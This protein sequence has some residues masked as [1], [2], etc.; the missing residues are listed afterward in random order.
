[1]V[2]AAPS[3]HAADSLIQGKRLIVKNPSGDENDRTLIVLGKER[4]TDNSFNNTPDPVTASLRVI[5]N[6]DAPSDVTYPLVAPGVWQ[7]A[8]PGISGILKFTG[9]D[10][11]KL[12][13]LKF[14]PAANPSFILKAKLKGS[15]GAQS[16]D[17]LPPN[18]GTSGGIIFT[19]DQGFGEER[20]CVAF[21][22]A[23]GG[24]TAVNDASMW[25]V[26]NANL[27]G[28]PE[29]EGPPESVSVS[30]GSDDTVTTDS[31]SDGA[32]TSD[33]L[34]TF[35][36]TPASGTVTISEAT[37]TDPNPVGYDLVGQ[38]ADVT[39]PSATASDPLVLTFLIDLT[40]IPPGQDPATIQV[41]RDGVAVEACLG[42]PG[43]AFPDPCVSQRGTF[44]DD[45]L[46]TVLSTHASRW[47]F[48]LPK[49]GNGIVDAGE[50]CE[51]VGQQ[52]Q[53]NPGETCKS[54]CQCATT[55]DC[56]ALNA[57]T[58][59]L[60][61]SVGVGNCGAATTASGGLFANLACNG[62]YFGGGGAAIPPAI[63]PDQVKLAL[64]ISSC[65]SA[66][67]KLTLEAAPSSLTGSTRTC[68][69]AG[70]SFGAPVAIPNAGSTPTSSCV[71]L[72]VA[73]DASGTSSCDG[74]ATVSLPLS[75]EIFLTGDSTH[76]PSSTIAGIQSCPLCSG[77]TCRGGPNN[78]MAC[79]P[80]NTAINAGYP[81]SQDCPPDAMY[82]IGA[83]P[84]GTTL[85]SGTARAEAAPTGPEVHKQRVFCGYC[86]DFDFTG[87][88]QSPAQPCDTDADCA[89]PNES[90][91]Q[92]FQGAFGPNG[93]NV[94]T[95]SLTGAP[96]GCLADGG[97]HA[98][99]LVGGTCIEP[100][101]DAT[102]DL[103]ADL[104]GP[105]A[106]SLQ[107]S[108]QLA[109][110]PPACNCGAP[111]PTTLTYTNAI[112]AG[113]CGIARLANGLT[114]ANLA[115]GGL[116]YGG[117]GQSNPLPETTLES[118]SVTK[119][120]FCSGTLL[121]LGAASAAETGSPR[122]CTETGCLFGPPLPVPNPTST[123]TSLCVVNTHAQDAAGTADCATG[124]TSLD[125][126][127]SHAM[128]LTGDTLGDAGI[129]P[130]PLCNGG[131]C[132][133]GPN[134]GMACTA[135]A[136][137][138]AA[139]PTS[140][141]CPPN[142]GD[143]IGTFELP[144]TLGTSALTWTGTPATN[145]TEIELNQ[146]RVFC[147]YC[148]DVDNTGGFQSPPK[149][150]WQN[151]MAVGSPC[152]QPNETCEQRTNGAFGPNGGAVRTIS[153]TGSPAG[154]LAD[155]AAH[156]TTL[157]SIFCIEHTFD[158]TIDLAND[159][160]GPGAVSLQGTVQVQ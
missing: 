40:A 111:A 155:H 30:A 106:L 37:A 19:M 72:T 120:D 85:T 2:F 113:N 114:Y 67:E 4:P 131:L 86:R 124:A 160:P 93:G 127:L 48:G 47:T 119:V 140:Q 156:A 118:T 60:T 147:G 44:G 144:F 122:T 15:A 129:Q 88:F 77:G 145:D 104:P 20:F 128:Y 16:L 95:I 41:F 89:Q 105:G 82:S 97:L 52:A 21:G 62:I 81:T 31:E 8:G 63:M 61:T 87:G 56:C 65:D 13:F 83:V 42:Q 9:G 73:Q 130:C 102:V 123:P 80:A 53:C 157:A 54:N 66:D 46:I 18:L 96:A 153:E 110:P 34:E 159:I 57:G 1:L 91:E 108:A 64:A 103:A 6:G 3:A 117:G 75:A 33:P 142:P 55:C 38:H 26:S 100:T 132:F 7:H 150:C 45:Y 76:D 98:S 25:K 90:C 121:T 158:P 78:G 17:S 12:L 116:Y 139:Y 134:N 99:T 125:L 94:K 137:L 79:V 39:A 68:S 107:G 70:C 92:R 115:C 138:G 23:A 135:G 109:P 35:V 10:P 141:D 5:L 14:N 74:D 59:E 146:L 22:G 58:F 36:T 24:T 126:T 50:T 112:G 29:P 148:R 11:V 43:T 154:S 149:L 28:C 143:F 151:G 133:G 71:M 27:P 32:T 49:C 84:L 69:T 152:A 136:D 51:P 101:F